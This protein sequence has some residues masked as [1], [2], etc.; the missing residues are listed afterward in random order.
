MYRSMDGLRRSD[1]F[2]KSSLSVFPDLA[3]CD[4]GVRAQHC[5]YV[6][7]SGDYF[8]RRSRRS[9]RLGRFRRKSSAGNV[10]QSGRRLCICRLC[11]LFRTSGKKNRTESE[12]KLLLTGC[13]RPGKENCA[14]GRD[15]KK[16]ES[17][18]SLCVIK[19]K[20]RIEGKVRKWGNG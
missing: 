14:A 3:L 19:R 6:L 8:R 1:S 20:N 12:G 7:Y 11:I 16:E 9:C 13:V 10:G 2:G 18:V 4:S 15:E 17:I 5:Q